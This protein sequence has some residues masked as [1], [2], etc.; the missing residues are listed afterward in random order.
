MPSSQGY[1][2][3][4]SEP[5]DPEPEVPSPSTNDTT[6]PSQQQ[7]KSGAEPQTVVTGNPAGKIPATYS[8]QRLMPVDSD[9]VSST[10]GEA[11]QETAPHGGG[12]GGGT[13]GGI[14]G[15]PWGTD[16]EQSFTDSFTPRVS[17][18]KAWFTVIVLCFVNLINYM[19]RFTIAGVLKDIQDDFQIGDDEGGLLQTAFVVFYM[20]FAPVFGYLGDRWSRKWIMALGVLLWSTTTLLGS[21]MTSYGWFITFRAMVGIGEASYS[22][23]APTII[24]DLFVGDLRSKMLA[25]F[26]FAIP[27]GSGLGYIVG[28]ETAKF[29]GSWAWALRVTPILG[30]VA[31]VLIAL[32][33]DPERGQSEGSHHMQATSYREDIKDIVRNPSFMLS[34]AGFTCVAFVAGALAWWGPKFIYLGLVSQPGNE[35]ITLNEV[36]FNFGAITM[37]TGI[38]GVP[39]GSYLSQRYNRKYPRAD[40]YICAIGLILSAPLLAGAMLTVNVNSTLAYVLIFFA[41]LTLN[42]NWAI[43]ADILLYVVVP[44]RRSTA[45]AF[46]ILISHALG[47]AG[48]PYFVGKIS[49]AIKRLLRLSAVG[50]AAVFPPDL[51]SYS[52][53]AENVTISTSTTTTT[54][55]TLS[56]LPQAADE[57]TASVQFRALQYA[58]FSTS[59]VEIIGGVFFLL[60]A[61]YI[62]RDRRN[63]E[64]AVA[65]S[66][67]AS[68]SDNSTS[69]SRLDNSTSSS[70]VSE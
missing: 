16:D 23:I 11:D 60:T 25:L 29:F 34:T 49:E 52:Q 9:S 14:V 33:R 40:A 30:I 17:R 4:A 15:G 56:P 41:E 43:V 39:L 67:T 12:G 31:V 18:R 19:D 65:E 37:A 8:Q 48:S 22:T 45:E 58:L 62:L 69:S 28:S 32:I 42:L 3:V 64:R 10:L 44:T 38:I 59:F 13:G 24:S 50:V 26:Y 53:L 47:D 20:V 54:T 35:N 21:F 5:V 55:T 70:S 57:D 51:T 68:A 46:Q 2:K 7:Q 66:H 61:M 63:V 6:M 27:V 1:R 36:S